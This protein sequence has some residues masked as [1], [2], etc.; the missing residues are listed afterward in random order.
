[1]TVVSTGELGELSP[2]ERDH[3]ERVT[4]RIE[5]ILGYGDVA[6]ATRVPGIPGINYRDPLPGDPDRRQ[7]AVLHWYNL[8]VE[9]RGSDLRVEVT[10]R[11]LEEPMVLR[12]RDIE[13]AWVDHILG[14]E[15]PV[16]GTLMPALELYAGSGVPV[17][18][19]PDHYDDWGYHARAETGFH[20]DF[21]GVGVVNLYNAVGALDDK[22]SLEEARV[23]DQHPVKMLITPI[24]DSF[25][26]SRHAV[27]TSRLG[28]TETRPVKVRHPRNPVELPHTDIDMVD[29]A[30][31]MSD[32][33]LLEMH[34][35][36]VAGVHGDPSIPALPIEIDEIFLYVVRD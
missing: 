4:K 21:P 2:E 3:T 8:A 11:G 19:W 10:R 1:M 16:H 20:P 27:V 28:Y 32:G 18:R 35:A 30:R 26:A 6:I 15:M 5:G 12:P 14:R 22:P 31:D 36:H 34:L 33:A 9:G 25:Y 23:R 29:A 17:I 7:R 13:G 24:R